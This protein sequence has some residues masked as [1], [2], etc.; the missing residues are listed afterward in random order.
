MTYNRTLATLLIFLMAMIFAAVVPIRAVAACSATTIQGTY[1]WRL[2][3]LTLPNAPGSFLNIG[4][5]SP[6]EFVGQIVFDGNNSISGF[7]A[8]NGGGVPQPSTFT[9]TYS[10]DP[11]CTGTVTRVLSGGASR[12]YEIAIVQGGAEIEFANTTGS[13]NQV[14]GEGVAQRAPAAPCSTATINGSYGFKFNL[15]FSPPSSNHAAFLQFGS[16][17]PGDLAGLIVF[18]PSNNTISG[19]RSGNTGGIPVSS[20]FT[21][22]YSVNADCTG[23]VNQVLADQSRQYAITIVQDGA[24]IGFANTTVSAPGPGPIFQIVGGGVAKK[25]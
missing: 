16:F 3:P 25:Q 12:A 22:T 14:V 7:L 10:V 8:G 11:N 23:T 5:S 4:A 18:D 13:P 15:L 1:G 2:K 9:G 17:E 20:T 6:A 24:E 19:F 21:G